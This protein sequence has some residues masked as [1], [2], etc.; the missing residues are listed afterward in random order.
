MKIM[1]RI[2]RGALSTLPKILD[3]YIELYVGYSWYL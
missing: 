1:R 2:Y 3:T